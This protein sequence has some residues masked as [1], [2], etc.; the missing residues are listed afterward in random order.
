MI[1]PAATEYVRHDFCTVL[2]QAAAFCDSITLFFFAITMMMIMMM[3][4]T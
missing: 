4:M 1:A 2:L 3:M